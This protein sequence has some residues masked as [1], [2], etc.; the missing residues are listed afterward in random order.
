MQHEI[1]K[2]K[3]N[4][5]A[6]Y[7]NSPGATSA[8]VQIWFRAGSALE[9]KDNEGIAHFLEHMFFKGTPTRPGSAIAHEVESFGGEINAFTSFD[10][11]CYYINTP[12]N[13]LSQTI[14]ILLD[15]VSN[16]QFK[17]DDLVPERGVVFEE[18]RRS[19]DNPGQFSFHK[20]QKSCFTGGYGHPILGNEKTILN[21]SQD[22]LIE[23]RKNFYNLSNCMLVVAGDINDKDSFNKAIEKYEMPEGPKSSFPE[24]KLKSKST[25]EIHHKDVRMAQLSICLQAPEFN[26]SEA[27]GEDLA[28]NCLGH[29]ESSVLYQ[30][31]VAKDSLANSCGGS[32]MFMNKGGV[33]F[34]RV[35]FPPKNLSKVLSRLEQVIRSSI[36]SGFKDEDVQKIK[37]QY[38]S[39]KV[40]DMESLESY[41]FSLGHGFAQTGNINCEED[42]IN[43]IR[44]ASTSQ[45]NNG[46]SRIFTRISH[47][48][49]QL[50]KDQD[51]KKS[52][53]TLKSFQSKLDKLQKSSASV[54]NKITGLVKS[55]YDPQVSFIKI[56][57]G[58]NLVYRQNTM[59]PTFVFHCYIKGGLTEE[60]KAT[61]GSYQILSSVMTKGHSKIPYTKFKTSLEEKSA[62]LHGFSGKNAYGLTLHGQ[63]EHFSDLAFHFFGTLIKPDFPVDR[64]KHELEITNRN[65]ENQKEDPIKQ[66]FKRVSEIHFHG[67]PYAMNV[68]GSAESLKKISRNSLKK[69]HD[70]NLK[71]KEILFTYC[72]D[73]DLEEVLALVKDMTS[74]LPSRGVKKVSKKK[75]SPQ[76]GIVEHIDFD[77]E[78]TQIFYGIP[79]APLG[80]KEN[81]YLKMLTT[82]LS[83]QS[84][85]L[86]VEVRD[87][88]GLCYSAQPVHFSALEAGYWGIYMASGHDKVEAATKAIEQIVNKTMTNGLTEDEFNRIKVMIAGQSLLNVQTNDDYANIY[89][90]TTLQGLGLDYYHTNN[91]AVENLTYDQFQT[92]LKKVLNKKWNTI[93]V[94]RKL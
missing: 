88:Q 10:Y 45:V 39:S 69:L 82:H 35:I 84:S 87:K 32:T 93:I 81:L 13:H 59:N 36:K 62:S 8:S 49:L 23:F 9:K 63:S 17:M 50:P 60:T 5:Q 7:I 41:A 47:L 25:L 61:N 74:S 80:A 94:G 44:K 21:F 56:K 51:L 15:M 28:L 52:E 42:F 78:Q 75:L 31:L 57:Q 67:H 83:G 73:K 14:N 77:R 72:G 76:T 20:L 68:Q 46:L 26:S 71:S 29:G 55:K 33:H 1:I 54:K 53:A 30:E 3:N 27:V 37:N 43:R 89:S 48:S 4:L 18:Y 92:G 2:L 86:F 79:T 90:V 91:K 16:P 40:Y 22:Q 85:E 70:S 6:L 38:I 66:C 12:N 58:I 19:V 64:V 65:L 24:F 34:I 11:T